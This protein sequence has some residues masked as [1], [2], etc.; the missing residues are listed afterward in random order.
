VIRVPS[1]IIIAVV[2]IGSLSPAIAGDCAP[3]F[4]RACYERDH[5]VAPKYG[6]RTPGGHGFRGI[7]V[8][9]REHIMTV[10]G[11]GTIKLI[12]DKAEDTV[13]NVDGEVMCIDR[14]NKA[15]QPLFQHQ[16]ETGWVFCNPYDTS[17]YNSCSNKEE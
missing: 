5:G 15:Y 1:A 10:D 13:A 6:D 2:F 14:D 7:Q 12:C 4:E 9:G 16:A 17:G 3:G 11:D 8:D